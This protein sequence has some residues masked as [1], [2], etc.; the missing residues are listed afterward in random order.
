MGSSY[1]CLIPPGFEDLARS[2]AAFA[3][4]SE[5]APSIHPDQIGWHE[6]IPVIVGYVYAIPTPTAPATDG[7]G[8]E[9]P[10]MDARGAEA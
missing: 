10:C 4:C 3:P 1:V 6:G 5:A 9:A 7:G 2:L 8:R